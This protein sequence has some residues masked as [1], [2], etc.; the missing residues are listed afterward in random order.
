M[1]SDT[2]TMN[3]LCPG[4]KYFFQDLLHPFAKKLFLDLKE[5]ILHLQ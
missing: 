5:V 4:P 1:F 3:T 2:F